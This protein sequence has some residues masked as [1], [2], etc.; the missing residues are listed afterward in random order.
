MPIKHIDLTTSPGF[1]IQRC[2]CCDCDHRVNFNRGAAETKQGPFNIPPGS[3]LELKVDA[4]A[5]QVVT[6][7]PADFPN[8]AAVTA[9]QLRDKLNA[10]LAGATAALN[11]EGVSVVIESASTG[12]SSEVEVVGGTAAG[13]LGL[14]PNGMNDPCPGRPHLGHEL[15]PGVKNPNLVCLRRCPCG[16]NEM[17][18]RTW[19]VCDPKFAGSHFYE[20]RRAVNALAIHFKAQGWLAP[21]CAADINAETSAPADALTNLLTTPID[22]PTP[23][24]AVG[25]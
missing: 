9:E 17:V 16:A 5:A 10:A 3:T 25:G 8:F 2:A 23:Q 12:A 24:P 19:D 21:E 20:H 6:F 7:A 15:A 22:I 11:V 13:P 4:A 1:L 18:V 14:Q